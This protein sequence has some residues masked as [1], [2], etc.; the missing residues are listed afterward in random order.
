MADKSTSQKP[1]E[2]AQPLKKFVA[3]KA[4][5]LDA[6]DTVK[7][8]G[9]KMREAQANVWPV[10]EEQKLVGV[11][12]QK[13]PDWELGGHGHDPK[14]WTV[15]QI[16]SREVVFC[17]EDQDCAAARKLMEERDLRYLPVVDREMRIVGIF[18]REEIEDKAASVS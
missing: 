15:G 18:S 7:A 4:G 8:A 10:A 14:D 3:E 9:D 16:M 6:A 11:V 17:Y 12:D 13:N 1:T 5:A 2:A